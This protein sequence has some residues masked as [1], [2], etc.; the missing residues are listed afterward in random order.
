MKTFKSSELRQRLSEVLHEVRQ[1]KPV[2]ISHYNEAVAVVV[3]AEEH[4]RLAE[5]AGGISEQPVYNGMMREDAEMLLK[6]PAYVQEELKH[7]AGPGY[8]VGV[9]PEG[10][11]QVGLHATPAKDLAWLPTDPTTIT[12]AACRLVMVHFGGVCQDYGR[13][14]GYLNGGNEDRSRQRVFGRSSGHDGDHHTAHCV[15]IEMF[16]WAIRH[17][18]TEERVGQEG[19]VAAPREPSASRYPNDVRSV[20]QKA[21][22]AT[23]IGG[24]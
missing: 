6:Q 11:Y 12:D 19:K 13:W 14:Y 7:L 8:R 24:V 4:R 20:Q 21:T 10:E 1:G 9:T 23:L 22:D 17:R 15:A 2:I 3:S 5:V 16:A 18:A